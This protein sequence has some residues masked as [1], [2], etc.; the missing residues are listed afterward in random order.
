MA[1]DPGARAV[2]AGGAAALQAG[3]TV[4]LSIDRRAFVTILAGG[5]LSGP[6]AA[7]AQRKAKI[8]YLSLNLA[9]NARHRD[10]FRQGLREFG[11]VEGRD[12]VIEYRDAENKPERLAAGAAEL[13]RLNVDVIVAPGTLAALAAKRVTA[14]IP[15]VVPTIGDPVADGLVKNLAQP[16]GN[17]TGLS[18]LTADLIGKCM[19]LLKEAAPGVS[20][21]AVLTHPG[22]ATAKT[23]EN[24]AIRAHAAGRSLGF[25]VQ[26]I[27]AGRPVDLDR[28][29]AEMTQWH[30]DALVVTP[31]ATLLQER[32]RIAVMAARQRLPAVYAY[33]ENVVAGGLMS[34][35]T[36]LADQFRRSAAYVDRILKGAKPGDLPIEQ[37]TKF[38]LVINLRTAE[39]L[40]LTIPPSLLARADQ[41]ID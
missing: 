13:V 5:L 22:A 24:Y 17:V 21:V 8:G 41:V 4:Q 39:A 15:I 31:Y 29:F 2:V 6:L 14:T 26:L 16:R 36:D 25:V 37:P 27:D 11:Y 12:I 35:G 38:E 34:Y 23:D 28:A 32:T 3:E 18:N 19:Q 33:R 7:E 40:G 20:R 10:A 1:R 9:G 30:A